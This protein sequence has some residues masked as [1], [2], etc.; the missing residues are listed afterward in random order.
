DECINTW[1]IGILSQVSKKTESNIKKATGWSNELT[2]V[3]DIG[4]NAF[5][6]LKLGDVTY[7]A[8]LYKKSNK[9]KIETAHVVDKGKVETDEGDLHFACQV[10]KDY[11]LE[12]EQFFG[13]LKDINVDSKTSETKLK[14]E[15][16]KCL[17]GSFSSIKVKRKRKQ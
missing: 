8:H 3:G 2:V 12:R 11:L 15:Q 7:L 16:I 10:E 1:Y 6:H 5:K 13:L 4:Y 9:I 17:T 14:G